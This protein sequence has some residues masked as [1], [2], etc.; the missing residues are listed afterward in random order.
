MG[1]SSRRKRERRR[2]KSLTESS[3]VEHSG[4]RVDGVIDF[5]HLCG[6]LALGGDHR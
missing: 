1:K 2:A 5:D 4:A 6:S 3:V